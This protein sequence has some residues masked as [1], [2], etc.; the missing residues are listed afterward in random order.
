MDKKSNLAFSHREEVSKHKNPGS[1]DYKGR[2]DA[3][4]TDRK[5]IEGASPKLL[6]GKEATGP[7]LNLASTNESRKE[8]Y[9][10]KSQV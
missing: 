7:R 6:A 5:M 3:L 2:K 9:F 8:L 10:K 1:V 4:T